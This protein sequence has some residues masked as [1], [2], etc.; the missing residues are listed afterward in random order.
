[1]LYQDSNGP[2]ILQ[3]FVLHYI[4]CLLESCRY[5]L[6]G[7]IVCSQEVSWIEYRDSLA[8]DWNRSVKVTIWIFKK[9]DF[10]VATS[11]ITCKVGYIFFLLT[12]QRIRESVHFRSWD[13]NLTYHPFL[14]LELYPRSR[15]R[16]PFCRSPFFPFRSGR[17]NE[18]T[19]NPRG[20]FSSKN[21]HF[22]SS[23]LRQWRPFPHPRWMN[24]R[25]RRC[26][27]GSPILW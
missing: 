12:Q 16:V 15:V 6:S 13:L 22:S 14:R 17:R 8:T 19:W 1:M 21:A 7:Q 26:S 3:I 23:N 9:I 18:V 24:Q 20:S 27:A 25:R 2:K 5:S 4:D 11:R 10:I